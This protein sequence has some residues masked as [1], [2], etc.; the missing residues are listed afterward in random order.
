MHVRRNRFNQSLVK[1]RQSSMLEAVIIKR[2][3]GN[4]RLRAKETDI[5][6]FVCCLV[7]T[8]ARGKSWAMARV[9]LHFVWKA[10]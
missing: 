8:V 7:F 5:K 2:K 10:V 1:Q 6:L 9:G 4:L 3:D